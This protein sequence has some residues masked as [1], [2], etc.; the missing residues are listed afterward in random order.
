MRVPLTANAVNCNGVRCSTITLLPSAF[1]NSP[2][3]LAE[4]PVMWCGQV[5]LPLHAR[6]VTAEQLG[7]DPVQAD[8]EH[9]AEADL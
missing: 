2:D 7:S 9:V 3:V 4:Q 8:E 1:Y 5:D 6:D